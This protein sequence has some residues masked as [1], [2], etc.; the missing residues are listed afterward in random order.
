[1]IRDQYQLDIYLPA[2]VTSFCLEFFIVATHIIAKPKVFN[3]LYLTPCFSLP[4]SLAG[5][6]TAQ[7]N[8]VAALGTERCPAVYSW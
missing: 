5:H 7:N 1:M 3:I 4:L 2:N 6:T 8:E